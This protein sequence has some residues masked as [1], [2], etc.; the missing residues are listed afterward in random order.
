MSII[1]ILDIA[2]TALSTQQYGIE[3]TGHNIANVNTPE[4]SRQSPVVVAKDPLKRGGLL[5]GRG[6]E[7]GSVVRATDQLVENRLMMEK[8]SMLSSQEME[9]YMRIFEGLFNENSDTSISSMLSDFWNSWQDISNDPSGVPQR[10]ALYEQSSLLAEQLNILNQDLTQIETDLTGAVKT[11]IERINQ[12][13]DEIAN[14]NRQVI[15][16]ESDGN[17]ANDLRDK[18]NARIS[19]LY[20][21]LDVQTFEQDNGTLTVTTTR[22]GILV[23]GT[24]S[25]DL[26]LGGT[27]G[28]R[29]LWENSSGTSVDITNYLTTGKLG[30]WLEMRDGIIAKYKLDLDAVAKEFIWSVNEQHSQGVG[31]KFF[32]TAVT[33]TY[34]TGSSGLLDTLSHGNKIDYTKDF[35]MWTYDSGETLPVAIDVDMGI[36]TASPS[37][38]ATTFNIADTTYTIEVT[39]GGVAGTDAVQFSWSETKTPNSGTVTMA[40][41]ATSVVIDGATLSFSASDVLVAGNILTVNTVAGGTPAPVV[42]TPTGTANNIL[43]TYTFT[44]DSAS[45]GTIGTDNIE[46]DWSNSTTS[47]TF[48]LTASDTTVTVD[49]MTLPFTSGYLFAGDAFTITTDANG[50]PTANLPSDWHWTLDSFVS[51]FNRQTPR[52]TASKTSANALTFTP[53]TAGTDLELKNHSYSGGVTAANTTVTVNNYDMLTTSTPSAGTAPLTVTQTPAIENTTDTIAGETASVAIN[54]PAEADESVTGIIL[55]WDQPT[56]SWSVQNDGG[57]TGGIVIGGTNLANEVDLQLGGSGTDDIT[58]TVTNAG[59]AVD[60]ETVTFDINTDNW[61]VSNVPGAYTLASG[62]DIGGDN[63]G[64]DIDLNGD[65]SSDIAVS[66]ATALT[67]DGIVAFDIAAAAGTY[68]FG[69]SDDTAQDSGLTAALGINT[70]FQ[71]SG[72][73]SIGINTV[74]S[75]KDYIAAAQ[76]DAGTGDR[77]AGDNSNALA[78]ADLQYTNTTITRTTVDR[79]DGNTPETVT[80]TIEDYYHAT[81]GSIGVTSSSIVRAKEF[82]EIMVNK[83]TAVRDS[84]SAVSLDEEMA[85]LIKFQ[86]AYA[87]AAKIIN[88]ADEMYVALL[89]VK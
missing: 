7:V 58:V 77:A 33:G 54:I 20:G 35:K 73:S 11:G 79:I 82:N 6:A 50:T 16:V 75:N 1:S 59:A 64:F 89:Q 46:I 5:L 51:Q 15:T 65:G 27:D 17:T 72:A 38:G 14:L 31:L 44:V 84:I 10:I 32:D 18:R 67:A 78:I 88:V 55:E 85:N 40:A 3:V 8:S 24:D 80:A 37:Y 83:L 48:T 56:T 12:L 47:G 23:A 87:A 52:V 57:F 63:D 41:A 68:S 86:H 70:F 13:T 19:E 26:S 71:G 9:N 30:G 61:R 74:L 36:S 43:D 45:G 76:I 4:Y 53:Y 66:F 21:Y 49:G 39:Q 25:F 69:F 60:A 29:V 22:G 42:M 81:I 62:T 34:K 2:R 28:N